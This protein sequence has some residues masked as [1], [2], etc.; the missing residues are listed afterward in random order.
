MRSLLRL[1]YLIS[2]VALVLGATD[3]PQWS[4]VQNGTTGILA[5]EFMVVSPTLGI[6]FDRAND[7][8]LQINGHPAWAA[9]WDFQTNTASALN[10][11]TDTFCASGGFL[12]NGTMVCSL[13]LSYLH[14][15]TPARSASGEWRSKTQT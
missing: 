13:S 7:D 2:A 6:M 3:V 12:S 9:L 15:L 5:L 10:A 1:S 8:P 4:F 11:I 14:R